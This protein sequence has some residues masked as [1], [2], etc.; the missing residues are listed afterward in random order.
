MGPR[1]VG[2][3]HMTGWS[4]VGPEQRQAGPIIGARVVSLESVDSTNSYLLD[5]ARDGAVEGLVVVARHQSAGRGRLERSW[6]DLPG[7][8]LLVSILFRPEQWKIERTSWHLL[9]TIV[10]LS[11]CTAAQEMTGARIGLK[12]PNDLVVPPATSDDPPAGGSISPPGEPASKLGGIL[13]EVGPGGAVVVGLGLNL[14][15]PTSE[16]RGLEHQLARLRTEVAGDATALSVLAGAPIEVDEIRER[17]LRNLCR[18]YG[19]LVDRGAGVAGRALMAEY[20]QACVTLGHLVRVECAGSPPR[21]VEGLAVELAEDG[22]LGVDT[23]SGVIFFEIGD[24]T[25]LRSG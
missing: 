14:N 9:P 24:V 8:S 16:D 18:R 5:A 17:L 3:G 22:R 23:G 15:W 2:I 21:L 4:L 7:S 10:A 12:W 19:A 1:S 13:S 6:H 25:H 20:R 11:A